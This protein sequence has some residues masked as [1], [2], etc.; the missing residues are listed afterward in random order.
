MN[1]Q[2]YYEKHQN[3]SLRDEEWESL[4]ENL[5]TS[6]FDREKKAEWTILLEQNGIQRNPSPVLGF[7]HFNI[8]KMMAAASVL[9]LAV[10]AGWFFFLRSPLTA[11][12]QMASHYLSQPYRLN[13]GS[14]RGAESIEKNRGMAY[15]AF[16]M[17]QFEKSLQYLQHIE[18]EG[19]AKS[20]DFFQMGLCFMYQKASDYPGALNSFQKAQKLDANAYADEINWFSGLCYLMTND[21]ESAAASLQKVVDSASSRNRDAALKLLRELQQ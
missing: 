8:R 20:A 6:K 11:T 10:A 16:E 19:G 15:E 5:I 4:A 21:K 13:Q 9:L 7:S 1:I 14:T 18:A 2:D 3:L 17:R 12:Q